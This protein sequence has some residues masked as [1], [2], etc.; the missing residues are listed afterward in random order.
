[1]TGNYVASFVVAGAFPILGIAVMTTL[2]HYFSRKEPPPP[3]GPPPKDADEG[4]HSEMEEMSG[5]A[6]PGAVE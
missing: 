2:P 5:D 3:R 1:M 6:G 4:F